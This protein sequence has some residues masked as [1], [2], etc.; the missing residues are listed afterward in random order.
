MAM[1]TSGTLSNYFVD[2]FIIHEGDDLVQSRYGSG[3]LAQPPR[4]AALGENTPNTLRAASNLKRQC[5]AAHGTQCTLRLPITCPVSTTPMCTIKHPL[6]LQMAGIC[7]PGWIPCQDHCLS[8]AYHPADTTVL[9]LSRFPAG[10]GI[11]P[12]LRLTLCLCLIMPVALRLTGKSKV[13]TVGL[14]PVVEKALPMER[15]LPLTQTTQ[16]LIGCMQDPPGKN[17]ALTPST[18][19]WNWKRSFYLICTSQG[20]GGMRWPDSSI[21]QR[22]K[23]KF[24]SRTEE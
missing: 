16:Q 12:R 1:S 4:Q 6:Q 7:D 11:A 19:P 2:S 5:L 17:A 15:S 21:L 18:R 23:L 13:T 9:N 10:G 14:L 24:G 3:S 20:T 22:D 8:Q